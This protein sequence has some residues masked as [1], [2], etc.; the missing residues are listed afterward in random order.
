MELYST[1]LDISEV[2][3]QTNKITK[4]QNRFVVLWGVGGGVVLTCSNFFLFC[5]YCLLMLIARF[6]VAVNLIMGA[7]PSA[8]LFI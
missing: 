4:K 3:K 7:R 6:R 5:P 1:L 2:K 8:K